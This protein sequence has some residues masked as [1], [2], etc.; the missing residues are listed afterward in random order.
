MIVYMK[1][2]KSKRA[3]DSFRTKDPTN[4]LKHTQFTV[5]T[6]PQTENSRE[7]QKYL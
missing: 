5:H 3:K 4:L 6:T 1:I 2:K 7:K